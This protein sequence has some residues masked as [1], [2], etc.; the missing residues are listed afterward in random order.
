MNIEILANTA[1]TS[2]LITLKKNA[3][4]LKLKNSEQQKLTTL[5]IETGLDDVKSIILLQ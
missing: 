2:L 5:V 1:I 3:V 4:Y